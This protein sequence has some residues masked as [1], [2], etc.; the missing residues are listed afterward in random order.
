VRGSV[1][2]VASRR[3][4]TR[5]GA[6]IKNRIDFDVDFDFDFDFKILTA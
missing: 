3:D 4:D 1:A 2:A 5:R 6:R